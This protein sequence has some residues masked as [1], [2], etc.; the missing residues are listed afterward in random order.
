MICLNHKAVRHR[1]NAC[2]LSI[3]LR[4]RAVLQCV[5]KGC[6]AQLPRIYCAGGG[7]VKRCRHTLGQ[8]RLHGF[9]FAS[10]QQLQAGDTVPDAV[11]QLFVQL[12]NRF[13]II[14]HKQRAAA[15]EGDFQLCA[16][17]LH[18]GIAPDRQFRLQTAGFVVIAGITNRRICPCDAGTDIT[19]FFKK[20]GRDLIPAQIPRHHAAKYSAADD[21]GIKMLHIIR[22]G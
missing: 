18:I 4:L 10:C 2:Y 16:K 20:Q 6:N 7:C 12:G 8:L 14:S 19:L 9:C 21:N 5:F 11:F 13:R 22:W 1:I 17:T 3:Q 15:G